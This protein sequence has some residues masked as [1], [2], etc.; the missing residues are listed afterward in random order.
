MSRCR[1]LLPDPFR[2]AVPASRVSVAMRLLAG[3]VEF[4][5][6]S[7][8]VVGRLPADDLRSP[9]DRQNLLAASDLAWLSVRL[10]RQAAPRRAQ[11]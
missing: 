9:L 6:S 10:H 4:A 3:A 7:A 8:F 11:Y 2:I 1:G 5:F